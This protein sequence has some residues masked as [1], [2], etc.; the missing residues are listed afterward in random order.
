MELDQATTFKQAYDDA[1]NLLIGKVIAVA[2]PGG[3]NLDADQVLNKVLDSGTI[4][5][6][7]V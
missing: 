1:N 4:R 5:I 7:L 6:V 3:T 2:S